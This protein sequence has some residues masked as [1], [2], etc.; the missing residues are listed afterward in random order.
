MTVITP[1]SM[2]RTTQITRLVIIYQTDCRLS[3]TLTAPGAEVS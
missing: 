3:R 2:R 1:A